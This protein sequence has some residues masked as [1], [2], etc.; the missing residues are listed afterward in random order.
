MTFQ[1]QWLVWGVGKGRQAEVQAG[2]ISASPNLGFFF[3]PKF[4]LTPRTLSVHALGCQADPLANSVL[5]T[6][7]H[8]LLG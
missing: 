1:N 6:D 3:L 4:V 7:K 5:F 2:I 8:S